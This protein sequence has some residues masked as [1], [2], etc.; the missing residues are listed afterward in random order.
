MSEELRAIPS[1]EDKEGGHSLLN[2]FKSGGSKKRAIVFV[3]EKSSDLLNSPTPNKNRNFDTKRILI[4]VL[5]L[6]LKKACN[7]YLRHF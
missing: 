5:F 4:A 2:L 3:C 7:Q 6:S 1:K